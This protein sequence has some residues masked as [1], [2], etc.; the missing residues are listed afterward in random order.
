[1]AITLILLM[2]RA[3]CVTIFFKL[4]FFIVLASPETLQAPITSFN[5]LCAHNG[6]SSER[7][8]VEVDYFSTEVASAH[9]LFLFFLLFQ[10]KV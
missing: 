1:M 7:S 10:A 2:V 9:T 3:N 8:T 5:R 6:T 4:L